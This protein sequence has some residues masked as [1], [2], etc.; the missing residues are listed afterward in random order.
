MISRRGVLAGGAVAPAVLGAAVAAPA[1]QIPP[2]LDELLAPSTL[3][4]AALSPNGTQLAVLRVEH[5]REQLKAYVLLQHADQTKAAPT[6]VLIGDY[7]VQRI[8]WA[9]DERLLIWVDVHKE[10]DGR[11]T[12]VRYGDLYFDVPKSRILSMNLDGSESPC[13]SARRSGS[14]ASST[15]PRSS[16]PCPT[17]PTRS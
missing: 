1:A 13:C 17:I 7:D 16:T 9:N 4:G 3:L 12:R 6:V 8:E 14:C 10:L 11:P 5:E 2:T 15:W